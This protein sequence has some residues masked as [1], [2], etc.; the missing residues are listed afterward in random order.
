M[1]K[2][3]NILPGNITG[4]PSPFILHIPEEALAEFN[5]LL[6]LSP[7]GP[8]TW[9]NQD[10]TGKFGI[11]REWLTTAKETWL[12]PKF[13]WR[14][15]ENY[16]NSFP[17]FKIPIT[18]SEAG[19]V[20]IH[21]AALFSKRVDAI[22][23]IF[24][25]GYPGSFMEFLPMLEVLAGKYTPETLPYHVV[26][27]SLPDYGLSG[28]ASENVEMTLDRAA[29]ILNQLMLD[30][31]FGS[32]YV[33]QGGDLGSMLARILAVQYETCKAF[34][35][36]MLVLNPDQKAGSIDDLTE[37]EKEH[38]DRSDR[39]RETGFAYALEHGTRPSTIGLVISSSPLSLLAWIGEKHLEWS[40][41][42][43]P[44]PLDTILAMTTLYW[45]TSTFPRALYHA[46]L[47]KN[48]LA[49]KP[50]PISKEKAM[51]YSLFPYDLV[52]L[53]KAWAKEIYPNLVLYRTHDKG[54]HFG[55]LEQPKAFL[56]HVEE[57]VQKVK[58]V[59]E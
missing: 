21:F 38:M 59:F 45:F 15:H 23:I 8:A 26:V 34:H 41:P 24:L 56:E 9:W 54:G 16:I 2:N 29:R 19:V 52:L 39:W 3:F 27:P 40:D 43:Y 17:N 33:A 50:H 1:A 36:N 20:D 37:R 14:T 53:P 18:D 47:V 48:V 42:R 10:T 55:S 49:G 11:S 12:S 58:G 31:G 44:I 51:G 46:E 22:P 25:H 30:L 13:N 32:G 28:G 35:V 4:T 5:H 6:G 57:F 7:I